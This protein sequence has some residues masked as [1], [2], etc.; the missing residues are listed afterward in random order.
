MI[1]IG[2]DD[3]KKKM[4]SGQRMHLL[5][6]L[7]SQSC[8]DYIFLDEPEKYSHPSLLNI[9]ASL[10]NDLVNK[11][12]HVYLATHSPKLI[13]MLTFDYA[14]LRLINDD[15]HALKEIPFD[16]AVEEASV[17]FNVGA[18]EKKFKRYY[19]SGA[20]LKESIA[21]RHNRYFIEALFSKRIYLCEGA[22][23]ELLVNAALQKF[24]GYYGDYSVFKVWGKTNLPVFA[25]LFQD[26]GIDLI[27]LF[28]VDDEAK[29]RHKEANAA[30]RATVPAGKIIEMT[31]NLEAETGYVGEKAD[32]LA[33]MD[34]LE[35]IELDHKFNLS[36]I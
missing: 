1:S 22:N 3:V 2:Q 17:H 6:K 26:L 33:L 35:E 31:P 9:T 21:R 11:G 10:I 32:A 15:T 13:S 29:P 24:G 12:K 23:D 27:C 20:S 14:D 4:G 8:R 18:M 19:T 28:D 5:L 7:A 34:H 30:I 16:S 36:E 25:Q